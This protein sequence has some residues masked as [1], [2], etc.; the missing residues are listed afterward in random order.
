MQLP[1]GFLFQNLLAVWPVVGYVEPYALKPL[2]QEPRA[3]GRHEF[4]TSRRERHN[5]LFQAGVAV[6]REIHTGGA[7]C[8]LRLTRDE[9]QPQQLEVMQHRPA[10]R[11]RELG[12]HRLQGQGLQVVQAVKL[13]PTEPL[14]R[15]TV[16]PG[17][18]P[19]LLL[20]DLAARVPIQAQL[21]QDGRPDALLPVADIHGRR[22]RGGRG[23]RFRGY[24]LSG[25]RG[26]FRGCAWFRGCGWFRGCA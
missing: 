14:H 9:G 22:G 12:S 13:V 4:Q 16:Q 3:V 20:R 24:G 11:Y 15:D 7:G 10:R 2:V 8:V 5:D 23:R 25:R 18:P 1:R 26:W 17:N 6:A 19:Q 21:A